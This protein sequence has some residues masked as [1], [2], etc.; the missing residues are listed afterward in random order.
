MT[1]RKGSGLA[2]L[3]VYADQNLLINCVQNATWR[4]AVTDAHQEDRITMILSAWHFYEYGN[5][6]AHADFE[7]L[8]KFA[9]DLQPKWILER[10]D[11][12]QREF[13]AVWNCIWSSAPLVFDPICTLAEA[14]AALNRVPVE[15][16]A[17]YSIRDYVDSF[18]SPGALGE[19]RAELNR[20][21]EVSRSNQD[22][23][24]NDKRFNS[25]L[26]MTE[27]M[28]VA[29]QFARLH[30]I[31]PEKVYALA[32]RFI[33]EEPNST[34]I[35]CFVFWKCTELLKA[36][37]TEVA[38]TLEFI[39]GKATLNLNRQIDRQHA[40]VALPYCD[41]LVTDDGDLSKRIGRVRGELKFRTA[42]VQT[43]QEFID[44]L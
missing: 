30:E 44:S 15:R 6:A 7:K 25:A 1:M 13:I 34:Q 10:G 2:R 40:V 5:A 4:K 35:Q 26:P 22:R 29:V 43:G 16:M 42:S 32:N 21:A 20:Q 41:L 9:E 28:Y 37:K 11:L 24:V 39:A 33:R 38:F 31:V 17:P 27:L 12:Q 19:I 3:K 8:I 14:G 18:S 36:Y 23:Y